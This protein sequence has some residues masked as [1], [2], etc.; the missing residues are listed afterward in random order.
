MRQPLMASTGGDHTEASGARPID[1]VANQCRLVSEGKAV[2][3][4]CLRSFS[5][6]QRTTER[7]GFDGHVDHILALAKCFQAMLDRRDWIAGAFHDDVDRGMSNER[8]PG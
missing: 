2:N 5:G 8:L 3:N 4:A 6:Q 7:V 1:E